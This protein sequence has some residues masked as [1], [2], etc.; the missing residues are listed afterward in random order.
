MNIKPFRSTEL[1]EF[2][3]PVFVNGDDAA[4]TKLLT[5]RKVSQNALQAVFKDRPSYFKAKRAKS[6]V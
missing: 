1:K 6:C 5:D 2:T 4:H 3:K